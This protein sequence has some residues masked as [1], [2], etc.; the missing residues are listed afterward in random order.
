[1]VWIDQLNRRGSDD[2][3]GREA[4]GRL[5]DHDHDSAEVAYFEAMSD[6]AVLSVKKAQRSYAGQYLRRLR[7][8]RA[9]EAHGA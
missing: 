1:M 7:R 2:I 9:D 5:V 6:P 4:L 3:R 8:R